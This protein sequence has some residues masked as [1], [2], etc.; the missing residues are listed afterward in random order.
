MFEISGFLQDPALF[1][2]E[3]QAWLVVFT[4]LQE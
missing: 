2:Y 3:T 4:V 1:L